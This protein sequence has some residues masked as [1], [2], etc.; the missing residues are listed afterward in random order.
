MSATIKQAYGE[1]ELESDK[2]KPITEMKLPRENTGNADETEL[3]S[4]Y[5]DT[6]SLQ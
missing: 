4:I 1:L 5:I 6:S 2:K 3:P